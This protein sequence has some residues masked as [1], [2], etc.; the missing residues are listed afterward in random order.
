MLDFN[1]DAEQVAGT[2]FSLFDLR[3]L[4]VMACDG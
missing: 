3:R 1:R 2:C 4:V